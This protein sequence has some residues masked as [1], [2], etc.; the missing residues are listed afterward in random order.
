MKQGKFRTHFLDRKVVCRLRYSEA[1]RDLTF[2]LIFALLHAAFLENPLDEALSSTQL[3]VLKKKLEELD[4]DTESCVPGQ[5]NHL[6]CPMV[7]DFFLTLVS[8]CILC[9]IL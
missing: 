2:C 9:S 8:L 5:T 3:K 4:I 7:L 1:G 6:L